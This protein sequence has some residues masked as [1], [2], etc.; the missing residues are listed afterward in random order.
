[1]NNMNVQELKYELS[2][3]A[4]DMDIIVSELSS[5]GKQQPLR[6]VSFDGNINCSTH[7]HTKRV[8][9]YI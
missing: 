2:K 6:Y 4:D 3:Y 5:Y 7:K 9:L 8:I 1:M